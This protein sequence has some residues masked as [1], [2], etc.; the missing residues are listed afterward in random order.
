VVE[1]FSDLTLESPDGT[2]SLTGSIEEIS[3]A[4][5]TLA[6]SGKSQR[7]IP[8]TSVMDLKKSIPKMAL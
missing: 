5:Q 3:T 4:I 1:D 7:C 6:N 8:T 2:T